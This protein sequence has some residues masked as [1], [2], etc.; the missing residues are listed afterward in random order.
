M[1]PYLNVTFGEKELDSTGDSDIS[2]LDKYHIACRDFNRSIQIPDTVNLNWSSLSSL[3]FWQHP[4]D[5][6]IATLSDFNLRQHC[7]GTV[8]K[9][10]EITDFVCR[11]QDFVSRDNL[12]PRKIW[13]ADL[14]AALKPENFLCKL[15]MQFWRFC[16]GTK[17]PRRRPFIT[18]CNACMGVSDYSRFTYM[19]WMT[20]PRPQWIKPLVGRL[21]SLRWA[22]DWQSHWAL[23][24]SGLFSA[25]EA[26]NHGIRNLVA[27][28]TRLWTEV[29]RVSVCQENIG[30]DSWEFQLSS[31]GPWTRQIVPH[32]NQLRQFIIIFLICFIF[33][34]K[35]LTNK[36]REQ[37]HLEL[38]FI[39]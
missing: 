8:E 9:L 24:S 21:L 31:S 34:R 15:Q 5:K 30:T 3:L 38:V 33:L 16:K 23:W 28:C 37:R 1:S 18:A 2:A 22:P 39:C 20:C 11:R 17:V 35:W 19:E 32:W 29:K 36:R 10:E 26:F 27:I 25:E 12:L 7:K 14:I 4:F 6:Q 13:W